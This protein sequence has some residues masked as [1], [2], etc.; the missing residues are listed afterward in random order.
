MDETT[1]A[2]HLSPLGKK[3]R[4]RWLVSSQDQ[5]V[6]PRPGLREKVRHTETTPGDT[7]VAERVPRESVPNGRGRRGSRRF[8]A[9]APSVSFKSRAGMM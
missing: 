1:A 7:R 9:A 6:A 5:H 2:G 3:I 8:S 4:G